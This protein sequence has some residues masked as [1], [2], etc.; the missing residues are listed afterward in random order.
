MIRNETL[1]FILK[2]SK[3]GYLLNHIETLKNYIEDCF[4]HKFVIKEDYLI[5]I[6]TN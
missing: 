6:L 1:K 4:N 5:K 2:N 3:N